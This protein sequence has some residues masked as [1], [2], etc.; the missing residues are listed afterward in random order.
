VWAGGGATAVSGSR[1]TL[2]VA[3]VPMG[4]APIRLEGLEGGGGEVARAPPRL[5]RR[6]V[7]GAVR[8]GSRDRFVYVPLNML[9][10]EYYPNF[11]FKK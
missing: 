7:G 9:E 4:L 5:P 3:T 6:A 11:L 10:N 8:S 1:L 2:V